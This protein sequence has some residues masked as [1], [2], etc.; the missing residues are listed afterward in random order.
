MAEYELMIGKR[1]WQQKRA[2]TQLSQICEE[3]CLSECQARHLE[4]E[5]LLHM[6]RTA[7]AK[8]APVGGELATIEQRLQQSISVLNLRTHTSNALKQHFSGH[9][10]A[11]VTI[12]MVSTLTDSE[13]A[14]LPL[15][16]YR[17]VVEIRR[18]IKNYMRGLEA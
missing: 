17:T 8:D 12:G 4:T 1:V 14:R 7:A 5:Y 18:E 3:L 9:G 10:D 2:G 15:I 11:V 13:I 6:G 16:S